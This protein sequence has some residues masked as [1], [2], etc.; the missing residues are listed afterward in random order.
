[1]H[2]SFEQTTGTTYHSSADT[3]A[4][5]H[6]HAL[7]WTGTA[8]VAFLYRLSRMDTRDTLRLAKRIYRSGC[9]TLESSNNKQ[10]VG[11]RILKEIES[12][13]AATAQPTI[14]TDLHTPAELYREGVKRSS[15]CWPSVEDAMALEQIIDEFK[16]K[17]KEIKVKPAIAKEEI[18][19]ALQTKAEKLIPKA[20]F[21]GFLAFQDHTSPKMLAELQKRIGLSNG[22]CTA[23]WAWMAV[24]EMSGKQNVADIVKKLQSVN[25][26]C[27]LKQVV[28]LTEYL[29]EKGLVHIRPIITAKMI[30]ASLREAGVKKGSILTVHSS[31][32]D[33]G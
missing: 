32:S 21:K 16:Q 33:F 24:T 22:W 4:R 17:L 11:N 27:K 10:I 14:A 6:T 12:L 19:K 30:S 7:Q 31:L 3:P 18:S 15:G 8:A 28:N 1:G 25:V 2:T 13:R 26:T 20:L 5:L 23:D 9:K 29:A